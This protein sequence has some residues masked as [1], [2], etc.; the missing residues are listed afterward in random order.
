MCEFFFFLILLNDT[1]TQ[2]APAVFFH[3]EMLRVCL[4]RVDVPNLALC[5][6]L[7]LRGGGERPPAHCNAS[8]DTNNC[9]FR[10]FVQFHCFV[11][12][13]GVGRNKSLVSLLF[14]VETCFVFRVRLYRGGIVCLGRP[15]CRLFGGGRHRAS[16]PSR[17]FYTGW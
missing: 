3:K 7:Y 8:L 15:S 6:L 5:F 16:T 1:D 2:V 12:F 13:L 4:V 14:P 17:L 10:F 11:M 9:V